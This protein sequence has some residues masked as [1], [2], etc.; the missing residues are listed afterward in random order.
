MAATAPEASTMVANTGSGTGVNE[1]TRSLPT[2][3]SVN[4]PSAEKLLGVI[5]T[6]AGFKQV[7]DPVAVAMK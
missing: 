1:R 6:C 5:V 4:V 7:M 3:C 2:L